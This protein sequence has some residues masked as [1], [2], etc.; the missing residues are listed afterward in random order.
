[1]NVRNL[2]NTPYL[3]N[4]FLA[5]QTVVFLFAYLFPSL[6]IEFRGSMI[7]Q[8]VAY[9]HEYW[10]FITPMFIHY[11][12]MHF[13]VNS[14][15]LYFMG[16]QVEAAYGHKRFFVIYLVSGIA[17][18]MMSF[19]FNTLGIQAAGSS[20]AIFG[21][22]GAF[23]VLRF[24]FKDNPAIQMMVRQFSLF[25]AMSFLFGIF[26]RN[27]DIFG[28]LGGFIAGLLLGNVVGLPR[29]IRDYSIHVRIISTLVL[30]FLL[31]F[32]V[33]FGMKRYGVL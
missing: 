4:T 5:I 30:V 12:L 27:V 24:H 19:G 23:I 6:F 13:A 7:G 31:V 17:G 22:Y 11:G 10:R 3:T 8:L 33:A 32:C 26:S 18:N 14:V 21:L 2:Q 16:Q 9:Q 20:T 25:V 28:H 15:V 1:M 29:K